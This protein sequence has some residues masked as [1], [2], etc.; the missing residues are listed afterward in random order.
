MSTARDCLSRPAKLRVKAITLAAIGCGLAALGTSAE[1][2]PAN[3]TL[4]LALIGI[5]TDLTDQ[6]FDATGFNTDV[7]ISG[8]G[9]LQVE[10]R[11]PARSVA[12]YTRYGSL[13]LNRDGRL[14][15]DTE[16]NFYPLLPAVHLPIG[17]GNISVKIDGAVQYTLAGPSLWQAAGR[18]L[19]WR[20]AN[21]RGL[22]PGADRLYFKE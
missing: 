5:P 14:G 19:V 21:P 3:S 18:V 20:F 4:P 6:G 22:R 2:E 17:A 12:G 16:S 9:F 7:A 8:S 13:F 11:T 10:V 15:V 1:H